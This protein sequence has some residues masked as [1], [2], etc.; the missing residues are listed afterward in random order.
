MKPQSHKELQQRYRL[1]NIAGKL[2]AG[3]GQG[4]GRGGGRGRV[5]RVS[6][7]TQDLNV[8]NGELLKLK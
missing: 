5:L 7:V 6:S 3:G 4:G 1:G 2:L 8:I